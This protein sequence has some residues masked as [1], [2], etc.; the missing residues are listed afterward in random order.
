M[1]ESPCRVCFFYCRKVGLEVPTLRQ[2]FK[3]SKYYKDCYD[4]M[5]VEVCQGEEEYSISEDLQE[6]QFGGPLGDPPSA[7][8]AELEKKREEEKLQKEQ[9][10]SIEKEKRQTVKEKVIKRI[11]EG[12]VE[13]FWKEP[14]QSLWIRFQDGTEIHVCSYHKAAEMIGF[15]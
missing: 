6:V 12:G 14:S 9:A 10:R 15:K 4:L 1:G 7:L 8:I 3:Q 5:K 13:F 11:Q 2:T